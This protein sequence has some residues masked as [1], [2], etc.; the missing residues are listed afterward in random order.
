MSCLGPLFLSLGPLSSIGSEHEQRARN[1]SLV[2][3]R[4]IALCSDIFR[5]VNEA[6]DN[7][8]ILL[9]S[10]LV[11]RTLELTFLTCHFPPPYI[12]LPPARH[13]ATHPQ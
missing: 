1:G 11:A 8:K 9:V 12:V 7:A 3:A 5:H 2:D 13:E 4:R 10:A 6:R